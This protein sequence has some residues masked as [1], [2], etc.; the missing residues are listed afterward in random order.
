MLK[1]SSR[2]SN[3][4]LGSPNLESGCKSYA[5]YK[6]QTRV[7]QRLQ[8]GR[9]DTFAKHIL[10]CNKTIR[11]FLMHPYALGIQANTK[12]MTEM[13]PPWIGRPQLE[14]NLTKFNEIKCGWYVITIH[15]T[16][17]VDWMD[18]VEIPGWLASFSP[19]GLATPHFGPK[20]S[21]T[22]FRRQSGASTRRSAPNDENPRPASP[23]LRHLSLSFGVEVK[24]NLHNCVQLM[25]SFLPTSS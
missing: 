15:Y 8:A 10:P 1:S 16:M 25:L 9:P 22:D 23:T 5:N 21:T 3:W 19:V 13:L 12:D 17:E 14:A 20:Q 4:T 7:V 2:W 11:D 24:H 6:F 18:L